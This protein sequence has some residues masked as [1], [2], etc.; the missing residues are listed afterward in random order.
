MSTIEEL[1]ERKSGGSGLETREYGRTD[2]SRLPRGILY[3]QKLA[4]ASPT[5]S[6]RS[7]GIVRSR[8]KATEFF[9]LFCSSSLCHSS[10]CHETQLK[11]SPLL[12]LVHSG[13]LFGLQMR[14]A[15]PGSSG[16]LTE[17]CLCLNRYFGNHSYSFDF[18][19]VFMTCIWELFSNQ[20]SGVVCLQRSW[21]MLWGTSSIR[22]E[23]LF[24]WYPEAMESDIIIPL[25]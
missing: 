9:N 7:V 1:P 25:N 6:G 11:R 22:T 3:P 13:D 19:W 18:Q 2:L 20:R 17:L 14:L 21:L 16:V 8:T 4:L 23:S 10:D 15:V 12:A 24:L 5:S